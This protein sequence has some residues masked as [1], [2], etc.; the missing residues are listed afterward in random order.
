MD[1]SKTIGYSLIIGVVVSASLMAAGAAVLFA[2]G[3]GD[4]YALSQLASLTSPINSGTI[5]V[6]RI[7]AGLADLD[8]ISLIFLGI[9]V[10][11]ATPV[12]RVVLLVLQF[13]YERNRLYLALSIVVL[14]DM[15][16]AILVLPSIVH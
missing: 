2:R 12:V 10:L 9:M 7:L 3:G 5:S 1:I 6:G 14:A 16:V 11:I 13:V 4:G 15:L 8:G